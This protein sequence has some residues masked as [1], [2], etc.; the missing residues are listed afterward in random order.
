MTVAPRTDGWWLQVAIAVALATTVSFVSAN[1]HPR[2]ELRAETVAQQMALYDRGLVYWGSTGLEVSSWRNRIMIPYAIVATSE[3]TGTTRQE[4]FLIVRW[5]TAIIAFLALAWFA[6][7][8]GASPASAFLA[9]ALL[10]DALILACNHPWEHPTDFPDVAVMALGGIAV[11]RGSFA[12]ALA[13]AVIGA[14]NRESSAFIGIL[15]MLTMWAGGGERR[16]RAMVQ[17]GAI[18][19]AAYGA[20]LALRLWNRVPGGAI[21]N[22]AQLFRFGDEIMS[23]LHH[24]FMSWPMLLAAVL[25]PVGIF[26]LSR[27]GAVPAAFRR[28]AVVAAIATAAIGQIDELRILMPTFTLLI[29]A[30]LTGTG[31]EQWQ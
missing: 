27:T 16:W 11:L 4:A 3:L 13:I 31:R 12:G 18:S 20:A 15:W 17:G 19:V 14:A 21:S 24:P 22:D 7:A 6:R 29:C 23:A 2:F 8:A 10:A 9:L 30:G 28:A 26:S 1:L 5:V 25:V